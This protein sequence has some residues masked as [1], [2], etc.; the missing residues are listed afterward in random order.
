[1]DPLTHIIAVIQ[2]RLAAQAHPL[3]FRIAGAQG[4]G[5][6]TLAAKLTAVFAAQG[7]RTAAFSIDDLYHTRAQRKVLAAQI[8]PLLATRGVPGTH[9]LMLGNQLLDAL[10]AAGPKT[11]T[12][13]PVFDKSR[14]DRVPC[15]Q[16]K[17]FQGRPQLIICEGWCMGARPQSKDAL[18]APIN[19]LERDSDPDGIWRTWVNR[20]LKDPYRA[21]FDRFTLS[22]FLAAPG[23]EVVLDWRAQQERDSAQSNPGG[24]GVMDRAG[25]S[26]FIQYF[27]RLT[28][29]MLADQ[30]RHANLTLALKKDRTPDRLTI[31]GF[32][33]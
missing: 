6:S 18:A 11:E 5:K 10:T 19:E 32:G 30:P 13:L 27:E 1:M 25:L 4:S 29:H 21:F 20:Q 16:Q 33:L 14:D 3:L 23:F 31:R 28:R 15:Q 12:K 24:T 17:V 22:L 9:D 7:V 2:A 26:R 8:H